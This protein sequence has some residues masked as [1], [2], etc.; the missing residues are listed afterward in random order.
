[1]RKAA[2]ADATAN[3]YE[4]RGLRRQAQGDDHLAGRQHAFALRRIAGQEMKRLQRNVAAAGI[5]FHFDDGIERNQRHAKIRWMGGDAVLA[6]SEDGMQPIIAAVG[7]AA[8]TGLTLVASTGDVVEI[9]AARALQEI[10][11]DSGGV[12]QLRRCTRQKRFGYSRETAGEIAVVGQI[13][14]AHQR[15][16]AHATVGESLDPVEAGKMRDIDE[17]IGPADPALHQ[18]QQ[19]GAGGEISGTRLGGRGDGLLQRRRPHIIERFHATSRQFF[20]SSVRCASSTASV[21]P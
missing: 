17:A 14:V 3:A 20:A 6:P 2:A 9:G 21:M 18:V 4:V 19:V 1:M 5:A 15:A 11:A 12:A 7:I 16:D 8:R 10:A 13:R